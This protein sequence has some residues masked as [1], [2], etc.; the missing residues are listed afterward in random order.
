VAAPAGELG[1]SR[2][3]MATLI[4]LTLRSTTDETL[5]GMVWTF[6]A[7]GPSRSGPGSQKG[8]SNLERQQVRRLLKAVRKE[9]G[10]SEVAYYVTFYETKPNFSEICP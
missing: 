5:G 3:R 7:L 2:R 10:A 1:E 9:V 6:F 4:V 8:S